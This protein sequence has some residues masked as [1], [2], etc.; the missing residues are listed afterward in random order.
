MEKKVFKS[1][2][3]KFFLSFSEENYVLEQGYIHGPVK[4]FSNSNAYIVT[5]F[6]WIDGGPY[7]TTIISLTEL[8][9]K[10]IALFDSAEDMNNYAYKYIFPKKLKHGEK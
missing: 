3:D 4:D 5:Y 6:S 8:I 7:K 1:L 10:R 2:S 9:N